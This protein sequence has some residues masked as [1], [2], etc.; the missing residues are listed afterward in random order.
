MDS[1]YRPADEAN[2]ENIAFYLGPDSPPVPDAM[3]KKTRLVE[4]ADSPAV[5]ER[6]KAIKK[7]HPEIVVAIRVELTAAGIGRA[8]E[9][10]GLDR[11]RGD[12]CRG[13]C[14]RQRIDGA[15]AAVFEGHDPADSHHAHRKGNPG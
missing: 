1:R 3:L 11:G 7:I 8:I 4:I 10:A 15:K 5:A 2:L 9:L 12:P 6:I 14:Q 13:R